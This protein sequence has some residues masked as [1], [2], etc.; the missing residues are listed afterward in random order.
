MKR[1]CCSAQPLSK[2][3]VNVFLT[4]LP[5]PENVIQ[6]TRLFPSSGQRAVLSDLPGGRVV[7]FFQVNGW[8]PLDHK[9]AF[10]CPGGSDSFV[11]PVREQQNEQ[12]EKIKFHNF[13]AVEVRAW[14][15]RSSGDQ[16]WNIG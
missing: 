13:I 8:F 9:M 5:A 7:Q 12:K 16:N 15:F 10:P 2:V 6:T 3:R 4:G 1:R 11:T 14:T